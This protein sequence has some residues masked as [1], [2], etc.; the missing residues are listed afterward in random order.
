MMKKGFFV[1]MLL[2]LLFSFCTVLADQDGR[3]C[4]CNIDEYG[5]WITNEDG[6][7]IYIMFWS[8]EARLYI[9]GSGSAPYKYVVA[10]PE[11]AGIL[12][13]ECGKAK[14]V[15]TSVVTSSDPQEPEF[16]CSNYSLPDCADGCVSS[17]APC[18][19]SCSSFLKPQCIQKCMTSYG[20]VCFE[21]CIAQDD[22]CNNK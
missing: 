15:L 13:M 19:A 12:P 18:I 5:C 3:N 9:M 16:D 20:S 11:S 8:E 10:K 2:T 1:V 17:L 7:E 14:P 6:D 21:Q 4:W 22:Y